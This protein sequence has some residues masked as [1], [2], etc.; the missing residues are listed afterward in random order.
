[1]WVVFLPLCIFYI[2]KEEILKNWN[3]ISPASRWSPPIRGFSI[4][5]HSTLSCLLDFWVPALHSIQ[6]SIYNIREG[7]FG[8]S[9]QLCSAVSL[10]QFLVFL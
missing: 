2:R 10:K 8:H 9:L 6:D 4:I 3:E 5:Q 1:M 7:Q